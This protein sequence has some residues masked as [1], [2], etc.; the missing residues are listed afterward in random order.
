MA[1]PITPVGFNHGRDIVEEAAAQDEERNIR[2]DEEHFRRTGQNRRPRRLD[3]PLVDNNPSPDLANDGDSY[4]LENNDPPSEYAEDSP[5]TFIDNV[6]SQN[7]RRNGLTDTQQ[8]ILGAFQ[9]Y[10][11]RYPRQREVDAYN[12]REKEKEEKE[13]EEIKKKRIEQSKNAIMELKVDED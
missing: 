8:N 2:A 11:N 13:L 3:N 10:T 7:S 6:P 1:N 12:Q 5:T 4:D 9:D